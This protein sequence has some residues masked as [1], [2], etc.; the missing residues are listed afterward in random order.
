ML[1]YAAAKKEVGSAQVTLPY[2]MELSDREVVQFFKDLHHACPEMP[3]VHYNIPRAKRFLHGADY[4]RILEVAPNLI[5]VK[6][7][8]AG[9][10]FGSLQ[11]DL[12]MTP[13]LSYFVAESLLAS[14]MQLGARGSCSSMVMTNPSWMLAMY[15]KCV[16]GQW[17]EAM[18]MQKRLALFFTDSAAFIA[19]RGE[20]DCDPV[21]D[22]GV[23]VASGCVFG[24]QRC[25]PPYI[26]WSDD[27]VQ[28]LRAWMKQKYPEY[29]Y[30]DAV[31]SP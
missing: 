20:G 16:S 27:T 25:R 26:G 9:S 29:V 1:E 24:H 30:P 22:K 15:E 7:T 18:A 31:K 4:L 13:T 23:G 5:G 3:L 28:S 6:Y 2:W 21:S 12:A 10:N 8:F 19:A 14:A 11:D 17:N